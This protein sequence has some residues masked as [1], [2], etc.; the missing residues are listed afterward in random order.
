MHLIGNYLLDSSKNRNLLTIGENYV[1][2]EMNF[3]SEP[4][5]L[6]E[7]IFEIQTNGYNIILAHPERY[8]F[9]FSDLKKVF[10]LKD[11]GLKFQLNLLSICGFYGKTVLN[12]SEKLI[13]NKLFDFT[14]SDAHN[15]YHLKY[16]NNK[17]LVKN[18]EKITELM[19]AN[20]IFI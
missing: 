16:F 15:I 9:L 1:L 5:K 13:K 10:K 7:I 20:K 18:P 6:Y 12:N 4:K 17:S 3:V 19:D 11:R 14:G 8:N 2:V